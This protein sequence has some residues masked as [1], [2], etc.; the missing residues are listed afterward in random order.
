MFDLFF[1]WVETQGSQGLV[2]LLFYLLVMILFFYF[3]GFA[4]FVKKMKHKITGSRE[5]LEDLR[6][7]GKNH[8]EFIAGQIQQKSKCA[9][10]F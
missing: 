2:F 4:T 8:S 3:R 1:K 5:A 10:G 6:S 7:W 9:L